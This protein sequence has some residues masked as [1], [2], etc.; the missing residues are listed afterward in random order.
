MA[1]LEPIQSQLPS[2]A[3]VRCTAPSSV[4][5]GVRGV[6]VPTGSEKCWAEVR[7]RGSSDYAPAFWGCK[8]K[9]REGFLTCRL[10]YDRE[11]AARELKCE[12][13]SIAMD[14]IAY[15][16]P[17][18]KEED[19]KIRLAATAEYRRLRPFATGDKLAVSGEVNRLIAAA[20]PTS[21]R[22]RGSICDRHRVSSTCQGAETGLCTCGY[23]R[24]A[25]ECKSPGQP[26]TPP[27][28][29]RILGI[30]AS[31]GR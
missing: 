20:S 24:S 29:Q 19:R 2:L 18:D 8:N 14:K 4:E 13:E 11:L 17:A 15:K 30:R 26:R 22:G 5:W 1:K 25:G 23:R 9:V 7:I 6:A 31:W 3:E 21:R 10:H 16:D 27:A 12:A 28:F